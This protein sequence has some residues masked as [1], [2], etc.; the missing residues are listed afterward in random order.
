MPPIMLSSMNSPDA[1][2]ASP[3][4]MREVSGGLI[5]GAVAVAYAMSYAALLFPGALKPLLSYGVGLCLVNAMLGAFWLAWRSQ[6][7]FAIGGP[8]GNTTSILAAMAATLPAA[9]TAGKPALDHVLLLLVLTTLLCA[10]LFL[11][12]GVGRLGSAVRYIP[13]PVIGGF[14]ASTGWL[15]ATGALRVATDLPA[16][17]EVLE[18]LARMAH[19][20]RLLATLALG[21]AYLL[22][23]RRWRHPAVMPAVLVAS[24]A[25][26]LALLAVAGLPPAEA[27]AA[28][29]LFDGATPPRWMGPWQLAQGAVDVDWRWLGGLWLDMLAVS[30]VAVITI[31]LGASGLEVMSRRD[32]S[33]DDELRTHG[34][35]NILA[36][37]LGGYLSLVSV[38]RSTVLLESGARTRAAGM[39]AAAVCA[40][41]AGGAALLLGWVPRVV[42]GGF[43]LYLGL[44][45]L[46]EWVVQS[47]SRVG[48]ADWSL[49]VVI[50]ATTV[51][52]GFTVAV[53]AGIIASCLNFALSY[54]R[55]GVVQHDLDGT[56]IR[57]SVLRPAAQQEVLAAHAGDIRVLVLRGVI[58]FGTASALLD[59][60]RAFLTAAHAPGT[61]VLVLDFSHVASVDSSAAMTFAKVSQLAS[62]QG[63]RLVLCGLN[64]AIAAAL[65]GGFAAHETLDQALDA[66]EEAVLAAHGEDP[67]G[68]SQP[69]Q[70]WLERALGGERHWQALQPLL[71]RRAVAA[72]EVLMRHGEPSD[73]TLYLIESGRLAVT[74]QGQGKGQRLATLMAGNIAGEMALY[75]DLPRSATVAAETDAVVWTLPRSALESLH[76]NAPETALKVHAFIVRTMAGR[77]QQ[78]NT[79]I[80]ALQRGA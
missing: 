77:M 7:P 75:T 30:A 66:A 24:S 26:V 65:G 53:L 21:A 25:A 78:A 10:V 33:L 73:T 48:L 51:M 46:W 79:T 50:L 27:R 18:R 44:A 3:P 4:W 40:L 71:Q 58:F 72:G 67:R 63:T 29:W 14:L 41:A 80:G 45:I 74:L 37:A 59:R 13:F 20:P 34:W 32:I 19:D 55:V 60:V 62:A 2:A 61:R 17:F 70:P 47:R 76:A 16:G 22:L 57:S 1:A 39:V 8:D 6:L 64:A 36:A 42:L 5:A 35:L 28:G 43:L 31:L 11:A 23:F 38:S 12:L 68:T 15:I 54:S 49:I 52:I 9:S 69:L 56:G